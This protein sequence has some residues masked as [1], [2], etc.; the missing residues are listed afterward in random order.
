MK[1]KSVIKNWLKET[2]TTFVTLLK[3]MVPALL[4]IKILEEIGFIT[5]LGEF[6][7]PVMGAIG[8][9]GE[10]GLVWA[11]TLLVNIYAGL[12]VFFTQIDFNSLTVLQVSILGSM[13]LIGH[14]LIIEGSIARKAGI[15]FHYTLLLRVGGAFLYAFIIY[16]SCNRLD[17]LQQ[18]VSFEFIPEISSQEKSLLEW[19]KEQIYGLIIIYFIIAGLIALLKLMTHYKITH[20][21]Q[22]ILAPILNIIGIGPKA[23]PLTLIGLTLGLTYG[24]GLLIEGAKSGAIAK[25]HVILSMCLIS[26]FHSMI[27]DTLL[28]LII[29]ANLWVIMVFRLFFTLIIVFFINKIIKTS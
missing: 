26:L 10:T 6:L 22:K 24:G 9:P 3:I 21:I 20:F 15:P 14:G 19:G 12:M 2:N 25:R 8:L 5:W 27:E 18:S 23:I 16:I 7:D 11:S 29:G 28:I 1:F 4:V 17:L 13:M